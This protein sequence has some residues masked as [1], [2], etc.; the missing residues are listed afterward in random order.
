MKLLTL[1]ARGQ[2]GL[3]PCKAL[4]GVAH[5]TVSMM[6]HAHLLA[7]CDQYQQ[8]IVLHAHILSQTVSFD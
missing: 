2:N 3:A 8:L 7:L 4:D 6:L 5:V 1:P